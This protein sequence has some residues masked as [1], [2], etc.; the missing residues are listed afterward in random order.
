MEPS[1]VAV[2]SDTQLRPCHWRSSPRYSSDNT[3]PIHSSA[4]KDLMPFFRCLLAHLLNSVLFHSTT[5]S[6]DKMD[7]IDQ[8][9]SR[10]LRFQ[11]D[12]MKSSSE[13]FVRLCR[14]YRWRKDENGDYPPESETTWADYRISVVMQF[15]ASFGDGVDD[16]E[17]WGILCSHLGVD[18]IPRRIR[19]RRRVHPSRSPSSSLSILTN[20]RLWFRPTS[21]YLT[22]STLFAHKALCIS[23][24]AKKNCD[25][26][27]LALQGIS[28]RSR[29]MPVPF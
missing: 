3:I 7:H 11:Y 4:F 6:R 22:C 9:F 2:L 14:K 23:S 21:I 29:L 19:D 16:N 1:Y 26:T 15:N 13:E 8:F 5:F 12:R 25:R 18:P 27:P 24:R 28:R 17:A 20:C 10:Y